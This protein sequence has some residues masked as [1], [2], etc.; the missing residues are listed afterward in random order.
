M[1]LMVPRCP[2][3]CSNGKISALREVGSQPR[4]DSIDLN[5]FRRRRCSGGRSL[6]DAAGRQRR[7]MNHLIPLSILAVVMSGPSGLAE[8]LTGDPSKGRAFAREVCAACH[9][10]E[11]GDRSASPMGA[12]AFQDIANDPDGTAGSLRVRLRAPHYLMP[13]LIVTEAEFENLIAYILSLR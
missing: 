2:K 10:V 6:P 8:T 1:P 7:M 13:P 11:K 4:N 3:S 9:S 12:P 5:D